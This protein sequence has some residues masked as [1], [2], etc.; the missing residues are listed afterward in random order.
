VATVVIS[1]GEAGDQFAGSPG[2]KSPRRL[3]EDLVS[4]DRRT[5]KSAGRN[6]SEP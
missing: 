1:G 3:G 2:S 5:S 6:E 4:S